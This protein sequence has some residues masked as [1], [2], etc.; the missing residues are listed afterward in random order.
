MSP[1]NLDFFC[2]NKVM[3]IFFGE[4]KANGRWKAAKFKDV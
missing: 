1:L 2:N 4:I 3:Q